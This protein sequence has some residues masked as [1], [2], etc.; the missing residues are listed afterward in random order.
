LRSISFQIPFGVAQAATIRV[1]L[2]YGARDAAWI[3]RAGTAALTV[4]VG[5][6]AF[7]ATLI[8]A[9]PRLFISAYIDVDAVENARVV[10]LAIQYLAVA[11]AFQL[12]DG[13]QAVGGGLLRGLQDTRVPMFIALFGYW[14]IGFGTSVLLAFR[15]D[16]AGLGVWIGLAVGLAAVTA[17]FLWRWHVRETIGLVPARV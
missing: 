4:G 10:P 2:G 15:F 1:G 11:A 16:L 5:A 9:M 12:F 6:M 17:L 14:V 7:T 3:G 13:A 8:W